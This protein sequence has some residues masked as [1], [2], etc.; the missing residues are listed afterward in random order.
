MNSNVRSSSAV[1][2]D[3]NTVIIPSNELQSIRGV[4]RRRIGSIDND[5]PNSTRVHRTADA[6]SSTDRRHQRHST[7]S[8]EEVESVD[9]T[10]VNDDHALAQTLAKQREDIVKA[11][12]AAEN[13]Q[14]RTS[15]TATKCAICMDIP[16]DATTT[17]CG[18]SRALLSCCYFLS[19]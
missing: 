12:S 19:Y 1:A 5:R 13:N 17:A 11:Q 2:R 9:L 18:R 3:S 15:L 4:K 16:T 10:E 7:S 8:T 6:S 14:G